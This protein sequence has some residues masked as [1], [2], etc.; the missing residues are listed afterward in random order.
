[1]DFLSDFYFLICFSFTAFSA[2]LSL[3][4]SRSF[5]RYLLPSLSLSLLSF[6]P[7]SPS[8]SLG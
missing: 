2:S 8:L 4:F 3:S 7:R 5:S 6:C 1:L